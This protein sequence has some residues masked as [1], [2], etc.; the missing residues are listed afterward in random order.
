MTDQ[1]KRHIQDTANTLELSK[2]QTEYLKNCMMMAYH[3]G[4]R[5]QLVED[6]ETNKKI[7][8]KIK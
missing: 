4:E 3:F 6:Y 1:L 8:N 5:D 2:E 7:I